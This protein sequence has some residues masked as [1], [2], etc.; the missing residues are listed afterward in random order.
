MRRLTAVE[1]APRGV[2]QL[3]AGRGRFEVARFHPGP[4]LAELVEHYWMVS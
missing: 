3:R 2:L 4:D 1:Q